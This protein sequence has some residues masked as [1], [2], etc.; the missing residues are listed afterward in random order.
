MQ[1]E[2]IRSSHTGHFSV[3]RPPPELGDC[4]IFAFEQSGRTTRPPTSFPSCAEAGHLVRGRSSLQGPRRRLG[5]RNQRLPPALPTGTP[6]AL[7]HPPC[8]RC[9]ER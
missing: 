9:L 4:P 2:L 6:R 8:R 3:Y 1:F 5:A 7:H